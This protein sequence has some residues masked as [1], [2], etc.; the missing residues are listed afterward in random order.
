M[1]AKNIHKE[2]YIRNL[3]FKQITDEDSGEESDNKYIF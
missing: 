3:I 2:P 1:S